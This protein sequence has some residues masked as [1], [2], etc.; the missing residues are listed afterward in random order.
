[1]Q[2]NVSVGGELLKNRDFRRL[3][4]GH[5]V[6]SLGDW[7]A[8]F[9][10]MLF[11]RELTEGSSVQGLAISGILGFRILPALIAGPVA[12]SI[13]DRFD[14]RRTMIVSDLVRAGLIA[15]VP[16]TP[17]L[18][19]VYGIAFVLEGMSLVFL[20][21]RDSIVPNIVPPSKLAGANGLI[22]LTQWGGIP[23]A[24]GL[25]VA[26]DASS[27]ALAHIPIIGLLAN[28]RFALP[29]FFDA[30][31]FLLSAWA[32]ASLPAIIG[33]V[34]RS[35]DSLHEGFVHTIEGDMASGVRYLWRDPGRR[36]IIIGMALSTGAGGGLFAIGIPYVKNTLHASDSIFGTLVALWGVGM[37]A[38]AWISQRSPRRESELFRL[39][40]GGSGVILIFM[41]VFPA[42][43]IALLI[44]VGFGAGLSIAMVLGITIAQRTAPPELR[45][46][47]MSAIHV[48]ARIFLI[49]GSIVVGGI[50]A[51]F[52]RINLPVLDWD[53]NR[54]AFVVAGI[55]LMFGGLAAKT[56]ASLL[57]GELEKDKERTGT[58][59]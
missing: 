26:A 45:G 9:G 44:A 7:V 22:M 42:S 58:A 4:G 23:I 37:A 1:L 55:A 6:S 18:G 51:A 52:D 24:G 20:P 17:N 49:L 3:L 14:R 53:G 10:L 41:G 38:G 11:V 40:L 12:S 31:T 21:A 43:W 19:A 34:A 35:A 57:E 54:Y 59:D 47:V 29:F 48:L 50:A 56:G 16:F 36:A 25:V 13:T 27:S 46:R 30:A 33:K 8:T 15:A 5:A 28:R 39:A 2:Q 32:I